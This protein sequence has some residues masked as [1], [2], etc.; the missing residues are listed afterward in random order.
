M[1]NQMAFAHYKIAGI[2]LP[3]GAGNR[4]PVQMRISAK[5]QIVQISPDVVFLD[6]QMPGKSGL[7][8]LTELSRERI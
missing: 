3:E 2:A 4:P 1:M 5:Q 8:L 7:D 6:I